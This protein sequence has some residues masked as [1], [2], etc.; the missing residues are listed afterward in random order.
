VG[1]RGARQYLEEI[2]W[3]LGPHCP[4]CEERERI[5]KLESAIASAHRLRSGV[6]KCGGCRRQ[7]T[8]TTGTILE[9]THIG[10]EK[11]LRG[12]REIF[13]SKK[14]ANALRLQK[15]LQL[16][17]YRSALFLARR[18]RWAMDEAKI[19]DTSEE[20]AVRLILNVKPA[21][22]MPRPGANRQRSVWAEVDEELHARPKTGAGHRKP[23]PRF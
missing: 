19:G 11:W 17:S 4:R 6:Y 16:G 13:S 20:E 9:G 1:E 21:A 5:Y 23:A 22:S 14:N 2:R 10:L 3:P 18:I 15:D 12:F 7:F 8:V